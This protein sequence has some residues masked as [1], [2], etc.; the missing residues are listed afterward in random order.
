MD[1]KWEQ[2]YRRYLEDENLSYAEMGKLMEAYR[3]VKLYR[4]MRFDEFWERNIFEGQVYLSEASGLNDP[5]DCL[6]YVNHKIYTEYMFQKA[7][8]LFRGIDRKVL[9]ETVKASISDELNQ[10]IY[11][12]K[13]K[14]RVT[15][16]TENHTSP[17]MWAHYA[18]SHKGFCIEYDLSKI[19][20][21]YRLG[22]L[23]VLYS[24]K[25][26]DATRIAIFKN[27]NVVMNPYYFKS[28]HW[29]YEKEWRMIIPETLITDGEYY[30]D[31]SEGITGIYL[32][33]ESYNYHK[34][35]TKV[36]IEKYS[37]KEIAVHKA[38]IEPSSYQLKFV[39]VN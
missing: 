8:K 5:F 24:N 36:I 14:I 12:M 13:K 23:P 4:Y 22:I 18:E 29:E 33:L 1:T 35:K 11:D 27:K 10:Q 32:G 37:H 26:Y 38:I 2:R 6:V 7:C 34:E 9:R 39:R 31:F 17:L 28:V 30:A 20:E 25:R 21:G 15:C 19:P 16:F 3:P